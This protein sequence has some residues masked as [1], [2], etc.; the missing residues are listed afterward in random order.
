[1]NND[2]LRILKKIELIEKYL[3]Y[4]DIAKSRRELKQ[5]KKDLKRLSL[6]EK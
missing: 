6:S 5:I 3:S 1:M 2:I 4:E